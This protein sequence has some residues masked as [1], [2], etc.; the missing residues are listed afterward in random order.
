MNPPL[1]T[2]E[3]ITRILGRLPQAGPVHGR[4]IELMLLYR[5]A[6]L[7]ALDHGA[8]PTRAVREELV[9]GYRQQ[10]LAELGDLASEADLARAKEGGVV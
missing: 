7:R 4:A 2:G 8:P 9:E 5:R 10:L 1:T 3:K 6:A